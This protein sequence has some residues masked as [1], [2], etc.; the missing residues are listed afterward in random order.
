MPVF[1]E[2]ATVG[3]KMAQEVEFANRL[4]YV[5]FRRVMVFLDEWLFYVLLTT[6]WLL[7]VDTSMFVFAMVLGSLMTITNYMNLEDLQIQVGIHDPWLLW[8]M[9]FSN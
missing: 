6:L 9:Q 1:T 8:P 4:R 3:E 7:K 2:T 5:M